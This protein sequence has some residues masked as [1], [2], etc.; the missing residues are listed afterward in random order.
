MIGLFAS[1]VIGVFVDR[2]AN[3]S[4]TNPHLY[5]DGQQYSLT[6]RWYF[7]SGITEEELY[8]GV[9][10]NRVVGTRTTI[11][12][13]KGPTEY[14]VTGWHYGS[15]FWLEYHLPKGNGGGVL[16]LDE[17]TNDKFS[18]MVLSKDCDTGVK[19]C[20]TNMWFPTKSRNS[21]KQSYFM[22]VG[23]LTPLPDD[24]FAVE[25]TEQFK[26]NPPR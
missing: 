22:F 26:Q 17:F 15:T 24:G 8:F 18:G 25:S 14:D 5:N 23:A 7:K 16:L 2:F 4:A 9:Q 3:R 11:H 19:Q 1:I 12:P 10:A 20:R 6:T 21:H 13:K